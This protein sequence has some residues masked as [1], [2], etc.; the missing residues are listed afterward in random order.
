MAV[1]KIPDVPIR[2]GW[3]LYADCLGG[4]GWKVKA[5]EGRIRAKRRGVTLCIDMTRKDIDITIGR[6]THI[7]IVMSGIKRSSMARNM[8]KWLVFFDMVAKGLLP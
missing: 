6:T 7:N 8:G 5:S 3:E 4:Y 2:R 1:S